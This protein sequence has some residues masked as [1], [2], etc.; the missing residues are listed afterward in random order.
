MPR[1]FVVRPER[2]L[3]KSEQG[4]PSKGAW[5]DNIFVERLWRTITYEEVSLR[6]YHNVSEARSS[7]DRYRAF[8]NRCRPHL[9][10][11]GHTPDPVSFNQPKRGRTRAESHLSTACKLFKIVQPP[12]LANRTAVPRVGRMSRSFSSRTARGYVSVGSRVSMRM[13]L[14]PFTVFPIPAACGLSPRTMGASRV[15]ASPKPAYKKARSPGGAILPVIPACLCENPVS[16]SSQP[17]EKAK[18]LDARSGSGMT[19]GDVEDDSRESLK[20]PDPAHFQRLRWKSYRCALDSRTWLENA[21]CRL[22]PY[23]VIA[24]FSS[25]ACRIRVWSSRGVELS[26][27]NGTG[28]PSSSFV[29]R[30]C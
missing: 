22:N 11:D 15:G 9:S 3:G 26:G 2:W 25:A 28:H 7:L 13:G 24:R 23:I 1:K 19:E 4:G 27:M 6:A 16:F 14:P 30:N 18:T 12:L 29:Q 20:R 21:T 17:E 10:L 8:S 5:R